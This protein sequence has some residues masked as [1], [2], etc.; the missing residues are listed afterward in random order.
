VL[1]PTGSIKLTQWTEVIILFGGDCP[2]LVDVVSHARGGSEIQLRKTLVRVIQDRIEHD[3]ELTQM[4]ADDRP[5]FLCVAVLIPVF[6]I[7]AKLKI[8]ASV[9]EW[10][11]GVTDW[12][13]AGLYLPLY[14]LA[15]NGSL[16]FNTA[17]GVVV[18]PAQIEDTPERRFAHHR[19]EFRPFARVPGFKTGKTRIPSLLSDVATSNQGAKSARILAIDADNSEDKRPPWQV[20]AYVIDDPPQHRLTNGRS[21]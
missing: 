11:Y 7:E 4:P 5:N 1:L 19:F 10:A 18:M 8:Y 15:S 6:G 16:T 17:G 3:V 20:N 12:F 9:P 14:S 2:D 13:E 21:Q